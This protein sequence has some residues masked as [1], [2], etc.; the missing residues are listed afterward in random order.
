MSTATQ[1]KKSSAPCPAEARAILKSYDARIV[2]HNSA[3]YLAFYGEVL[4]QGKSVPYLLIPDKAG[5]ARDVKWKKFSSQE[6]T[7]RIGQL[8]NERTRAQFDAQL[9][10]GIA[11]AE[12][13]AEELGIVLSHK[14]LEILVAHTPSV[15]DR[16]AALLN[17]VERAAE[18][19][20]AHEVAERTRAAINLANYPSFFHKTQSMKR[21]FIALLGEPN[22]GKT[23]QAIEALA[24]ARNGVYLAP[25]RLLALENYER[26][27]DRGVAVSMVTGE[28]CR[29]TE[30]ATHVASTI[31]ML[32][33]HQKVEVAVIDEVQMLEDPDRGAAWTAAIC[34]APAET[35]YLVGSL[36]AQAAVEAL[37]ARL[38]CELE[39]HTLARKV[40]LRLESEPLYSERQLRKGDAV[41]AF[42]RRDVLFWR[43]AL[44][45]AGFSVATVYGNLSPEVRR[46]QATLFREGKVDILVGTDAL[47]MGLNMP[48]SRVIFSTARKFDGQEECELP[49]WLVQQIGGRAGRFGLAESGSVGGFETE[50]HRVICGLMKAPLKRVRTRGFYVAPS[51]EHLQEIAEVAGTTAL[52]ALLKHFVQDTTM[53]DAFFT[54]ANLADQLERAPWLDSL[55]LSLED[56]FLLSLLPLSTKAEVLDKAFREWSINVSRA[57]VT[58]LTRIVNVS[59]SFSLQSAEDACKFY[60]AYAWLSYRR[61]ELFP[62]VERALALVQE[63]SEAID[64]LLRKQNQRR[65]TKQGR[66]KPAKGQLVAVA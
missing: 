2:T 48:I 58:R 13:R 43:D 9:Q 10:A 36:T 65:M 53:E 15:K 54:P 44:I 23:H 50:T 60:S 17:R 6:Q 24:A 61:P 14:Q 41:I 51:L 42:S 64:A 7:C 35:V 26:L 5:L 47:A 63:T 40:P 18:K 25:L 30:G 62:D 55:P 20:R 37:A 34:G 12:Q 3:H 66:R 32:D 11:R 27:R 56:K 39:V 33:Y 1:S 52:E 45:A 28:E 21:K 57:R 22:S 31:E 16:L 59:V 49:A 8:A 46:A 4:F 38:G 29:L 19:R